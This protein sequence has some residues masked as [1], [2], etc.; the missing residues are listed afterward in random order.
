MITSLSLFI[1]NIEYFA[2]IIFLAMALLSTYYFILTF[3]F[4]ITSFY[5]SFNERQKKTINSNNNS[6]DL[7]NFLTYSNTLVILTIIYLLI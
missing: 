7:D 2:D 6:N 3:V 4:E 5:Y 1:L